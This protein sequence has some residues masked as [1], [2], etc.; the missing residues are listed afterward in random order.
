MGRRLP[1][2]ALVNGCAWAVLLQ[3][4]AHYC[5]AI[6]DSLSWL[7]GSS[8]IVVCVWAT[9][10]AE[11][12]SLARGILEKMALSDLSERARAVV[13][14]ISVLAAVY[15]VLIPTITIGCDRAGTVRIEPED[16]APLE[17][18]C[19]PERTMVRAPSGFVPAWGLLLKVTDRNERFAYRELKPL[20]SNAIRVPRDLASPTAVL[21]QL[22][23]IDTVSLAASTT[24]EVTPGCTEKAPFCVSFDVLGSKG[25]D[26]KKNGLLFGRTHAKREVLDDRLRLLRAEF[27]G[28]S[29]PGEPSFFLTSKLEDLSE[30]TGELRSKKDGQCQRFRCRIEPEEENICIIASTGGC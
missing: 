15:A 7:G 6:A 14:G 3:R 30:L 23:G 10:E 9:Q 16:R 18:Q 29:D 12:K 19:S 22:S 13:T 4:A 1:P 26:L 27:G 20:A 17:L 21:V 5:F 28:L 8:L 24:V 25:F 2:Y 11:G